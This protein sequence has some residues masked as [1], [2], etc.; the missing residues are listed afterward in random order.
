MMKDRLFILGWIAAALL[1]LGSHI[2]GASWL[3]IAM[4]SIGWICWSFMMPAI[5]DALLWHWIN[6][7]N[8][9]GAVQRLREQGYL[10]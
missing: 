5:T 7:R 1:C 6:S 9:R 4:I 8:H 10:E 3:K 2:L